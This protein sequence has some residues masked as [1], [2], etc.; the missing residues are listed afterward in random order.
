MSRPLW[1][2]P[3][4]KKKRKQRKKKKTSKYPYRPKSKTDFYRSKLWRELRVRVL[5]SYSCNC[6]MC[7][8]SPKQH[9]V[10]LHVDHIKPRS[11]YPELELSF[12]NLQILCDD[13]NLGKSNKFK[14]DHRPDLSEADE[15]LD[16]I[17][18]ESIRHL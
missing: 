10:V 14:T 9:G 16:G 15:F 13:C 11:K 12:S 8:R 3:G 17:H 6:M 4:T 1:N 5:E 7:G 18:L 2:E